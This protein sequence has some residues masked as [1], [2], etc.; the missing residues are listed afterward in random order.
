MSRDASPN[1]ITYEY[2][3]NHSSPY[4]RA[5]PPCEH[6]ILSQLKVQVFEKDQ[7]RRNYN[8][9]LG[10]F[11]K[12]QEEL[13]KIS[14]IKERNEIA[15]NQLE[16]DKRNKEIADLRNKNENLFNELNERIALNKKLYSENNNLFHEL[17]S[18]TSE[19]QDLQDHICDNER[20]L[21]RL[22][23]EKEDIEK[24]IYN[25]S[26]IKEKQ[27]KDLLELKSEIS[28]LSAKNDAQD[29][30]LRNRNDQNI[31][32]V[33]ELNEEK[34]NYKNLFIELRNKEANLVTCEQKLNNANDKIRGLQNNINSLN[35]L[36]NKNKND[37]SVAKDNLLKETSVLNQ[38]ITD[39]THLNELVEDRNAHIKNLNNE[40][41]I[42]NKNNTELNCDNTKLNNRI[43]AYKRHLMLLI[44]QNKKLACEINL[45][46]GRDNELKGI[47]ER[48]IHLQDVK[49]ENGQIINNS[50]EKLK[51]YLDPAQPIEESKNNIIV[52]RTYSIGRNDN[53][54]GN[55]KSGLINSNMNMNL[56][57]SGINQGMS[58]TSI[59][60]NINQKD[61]RISQENME[62]QDQGEGE[63]EMVNM[64]E[65]EQ[66]N[67]QE[68]EHEENM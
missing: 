25:L 37:I 61:I 33:N 50:Q 27:E 14:Q 43:Q 44:C 18:K 48:D 24:K 46:I 38:L 41:D 63:E 47:L 52:K 6:D 39:N 62:E 49:L 17:E 28:N 11:K 53:R 64:D 16:K 20:L 54:N 65:N 9:L 8:N 1:S 31:N 26:Q 3:S 12:L 7:N 2:N 13:A 68:N 55:E 15:L 19:N 22:S 32:L 56:G 23:C 45:L 59:I 57:E 10:K 58:G 66:E 42:I 67:E 60:N 30:L 29:N 5:S 4:R 51:Q 36:L 40:N 35:N 21:K 34:N